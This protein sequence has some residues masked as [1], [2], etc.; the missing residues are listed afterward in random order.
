MFGGEITV[1]KTKIDT[2]KLNRE[3]CTHL[4]EI[5]KSAR[6]CKYLRQLGLSE[7][8]ETYFNE[9]NTFDMSRL[10]EFVEEFRTKCPISN[11]DDYASLI[12]SI[13]SRA[14]TDVLLPGIPNFFALSSGTAS[15]KSKIIPNY[16]DIM[17]EKSYFEFPHDIYVGIV[18]AFG[19]SQF[20][21][22]SKGI[23]L[24]TRYIKGY[25]PVNKLPI[26][27]L[28]TISGR[29]QND[30]EPQF[31]KHETDYKT[32]ILT[33]LVYAASDRD[34]EYIKAVFLVTVVDF[35]HFFE[36]E[37]LSIVDHIEKGTL[38]YSSNQKEDDFF[39]GSKKIAEICLRPNKS[40]ADELRKLI[41]DEKQAGNQKI[42]LKNKINLIWPK[43]YAVFAIYSGSFE[44]CLNICKSFCPTAFYVNSVYGS[45]EGLY[46]IGLP[47]KDNYLIMPSSLTYSIYSFIEFIPLNEAESTKTLLLNEL[48]VGQTYDIVITSPL[49]GLIR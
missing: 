45:S 39:Y 16:Y 3:T 43:F 25:S 11:Y 46:A 9:S 27:N 29:L 22:M 12:D 33:G 48:E 10:N 42:N 36:Q 34:L 24:L 41:L 31:A 19:I 8:F 28:S 21:R 2:E 23:D 7:S 49:T 37:F 6:K 30:V 18:Q 5:I 4:V 17:R 1:D 40:R 35:F 13:Y 15:G 20:N 26:C 47:G 32:R 44:P 38:P 14:E